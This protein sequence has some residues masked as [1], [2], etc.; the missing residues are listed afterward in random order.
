MHAEGGLKAI[1]EIAVGEKVWCYDHRRLCWSEREVVET[2]RRLHRGTMATLGVAG[3]RVRA[4]EGHPF[5][6]VR[7]EGL[8]GRPV[9]EEVGAYVVD[10]RQEGRWV[11]ARD[12]RAGDAVLLRQ[13][14]VAELESVR[15][16]EVEEQ[17]Y[18]FHVAELQNYAVGGSGVLVH[19]ISAVTRTPME[20]KIP[21]NEGGAINAVGKAGGTEIEIIANMS[22]TRTTIT[23]D[24]LHFTK[25]AGGTLGP[26]QLQEFGRDFLRQHGNGATELVINPAPR[27]TG[28]TAGSGVP[29]KQI[30]ITLE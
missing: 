21:I 12:L 24:G 30:R 6:V 4:T 13:G 17:V 5:W 10:G 20:W 8:A 7:G 28:A 25:N 2:F 22:R 9:P 1:E 11:Q 19:N 15:L 16:D 29:P 26:K 14:T 3:E 27:T 23:L 18:N